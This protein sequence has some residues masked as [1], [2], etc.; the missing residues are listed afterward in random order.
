MIPGIWNYGVDIFGNNVYRS[1]KDP[2]ADA[3]ASLNH[4]EV[5]AFRGVEL[6]I[7]D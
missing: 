1:S 4:I 5:Q 7:P 6:P 3:K 2:K